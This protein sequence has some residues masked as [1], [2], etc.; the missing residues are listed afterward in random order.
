[1]IRSNNSAGW[2][3]GAETAETAAMG[4]HLGP[5]DYA[6]RCNLVHV[7]DGTMKDFTAGHTL[8]DQ[9]LA[10]LDAWLDAPPQARSTQHGSPPD[11]QPDVLHA[12][13]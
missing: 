7:P 12:R 2:G 4:I 11:V 5:N 1:M 3:S 9:T 8:S 6:I 13:G 10:A